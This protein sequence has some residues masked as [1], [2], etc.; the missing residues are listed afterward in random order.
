MGVGGGLEASRP[1]ATLSAG[2]DRS[3]EEALQEKEE[4]NRPD[5]AVPGHRGTA[6]G[7]LAPRPEH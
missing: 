3:Q 4:G 5:A 2:D 7:L 1:G 6:L